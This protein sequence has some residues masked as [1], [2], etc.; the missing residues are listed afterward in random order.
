MKDKKYWKGFCTGVLAVI[1]VL[2]VFVLVTTASGVIDWRQL[3][4]VTSGS[5]VNAKTERKEKEIQAYIDMYYLDEI[6]E[7]TMQ[8]SICRG[9][10]DGLGDKYAA[11][12]NEEDY[13]D[14]TEKTSGNYCGIGA[15][16]SQNATTGAITIIQPMEDSPAKRAGLQS[17]DVIYKVDGEEVTGEDL[18]T[19][20]SMMKGEPGTKVNLQIVRPGENDY[21]DVTVT[22]AEIE[23]KTVVCKMLDNKIGYIGVSAFE[24]ATKAQF[25]TAVEEL[26]QQ[27]EK[28]LIID[29]RDNGGGLLSTAV[30]MLDRMLP[31]GRVVYTQDKSGNKEEYFSDNKESFDK[32]VVILVNENS[33]SASEV[34]AGAMQ[35]Y[36]KAVLLGTT[37]FGKGIVQGVFDLSDGTAI[38]LTTSKYYTP[39]GR[40]I[41]G[42]GLEPDQKVALSDKT[43]KLKETGLTVDNQVYAAFQYLQNH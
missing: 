5:V 30:D 13:E 10:L 40:N 39:K 36:E 18:S 37:T 33:A 20:V 31:E 4:P 25:R 21:I 15:Y 35:D 38:K 1:T 41:H 19:V 22:R 9:I 14:L 32:P 28:G 17:G 26:E 27:G 42:T 8:D 29:L 12:Y 24:E 7:K 2:S 16:V 23:T 34:F 3:L 11:Y 43:V 6:D